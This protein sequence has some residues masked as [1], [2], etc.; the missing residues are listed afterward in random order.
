MSGNESTYKSIPS[1]LAILIGFVLG[2]SGYDNIGRPLLIVGGATL[3]TTII[4]ISL[5]DWLM[6]NISRNRRGIKISKNKKILTESALGVMLTAYLFVA[7]KRLSTAIAVIAIVSAMCWAYLKI[8]SPN[9]LLGSL[10]ISATIFLSFLF[11]LL[12]LI[13]IFA[14]I[15]DWLVIVLAVLVVFVLVGAYIEHKKQPNIPQL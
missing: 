9:G 4:K 11:V 2:I 6:D 3:A 12:V 7:P 13:E 15:N 8:S 14:N 10:A 1:F 5:V